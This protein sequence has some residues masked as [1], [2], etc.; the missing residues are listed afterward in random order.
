MR[1]Y[2]RPGSARGSSSSRL[3]PH[4]VEHGRHLV[5]PCA[6]RLIA[7]A[8][9]P[10]A[11]VCPQEPVSTNGGQHASQGNAAI[12]ENDQCARRVGAAGER[13]IDRDTEH[14]FRLA[15]VAVA[16]IPQSEGQIGPPVHVRSPPLGR[17]SST[18]V[19]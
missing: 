6:V 18:A 3:W 15:W 10:L 7:L 2:L 11:N 16:G 14:P 19:S 4:A 1:S 8:A 12:F 17:A 13:V 9:R 5:E